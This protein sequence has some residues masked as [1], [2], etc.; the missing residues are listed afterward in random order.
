MRDLRSMWGAMGLQVRTMP[1]GPGHEQSQA[2]ELANS[3]SHGLALI[4]AL[5]GGPYLIVQ[6]TRRADAAFVVGTSLF[7]A[8]IA[9]LY[10]ASTLYHALPRAGPSASSG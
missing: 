8:T 9:I 7:C 1:A 5:I 6:A 2:E 10:L 4:A 3:L